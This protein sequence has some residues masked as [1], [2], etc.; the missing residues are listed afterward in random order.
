MLAPVT[1]PIRVLLLDDHPIVRAGLRML[2]NSHPGLKVAG[3]AGDCDMALAI[4][5]REQPDVIIVDLDLG[6]RS[7]LDAIPQLLVAVPRARI[8][9]LTGVSNPEAHSRAVELG[10]LGVVRKDEAN[11]VIIKAIEKVHGGEAWLDG[12]TMGRA[13]DHLRHPRNEIR[14]TD[15][16][17]A[18]ISSLSKREREIIALVCKG[19][20]N[21]Q[22]ADHLSISEGTVRN[23][24]TVIYEKLSVSDRFGLIVYANQHNLN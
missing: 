15:P 19:Y 13:L 21:Q 17:V 23:H 18:R 3:E 7:G 20:K 1:S 11:E 2:I 5:A 4:A 14:Q 6:C 10:A 22:A 16:D 8:L 9:V 24:L 12:D